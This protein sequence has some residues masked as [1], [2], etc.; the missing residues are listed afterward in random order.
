MKLGKKK[1]RKAK[2]EIIPLIDIV[3]FLLATMVLI[4]M[5]MSQNAGLNVKVPGASTAQAQDK[6]ENNTATITV[7]Q[8]GSMFYNK[9]KVTPP[10][11]NARLQ[12]LKATSKDA[13]VIVNSDGDASW[14][15]VVRAVD[16]VKRLGIQSVGLSVEKK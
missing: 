3:F 8:D 1:E 12:G 2:I 5:S 11:L 4:N 6:K 10:Q 15:Q 16:E 13:Q 7:M 9:E 14:T